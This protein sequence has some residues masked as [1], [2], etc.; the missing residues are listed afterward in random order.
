MRL[1]CGV[2]LNRLHVGCTTYR[3]AGA[4]RSGAYSGSTSKVQKQG[5]RSRFEEYDEQLDKDLG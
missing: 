2:L 3:M 4:A 1:C 5:Q